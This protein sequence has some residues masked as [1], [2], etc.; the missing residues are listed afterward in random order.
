M[1]GF[2]INQLENHA[3]P[4]MPEQWYANTA[5]SQNME[6]LFDELAS[7]DGAERVKS[8]PQFMQNLGFAPD[9]R[10]ADLMVT[11]FGQLNAI[12]GYPT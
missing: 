11:D 8:Q 5:A 1:Q 2:D 6:T 4:P 9:A 10:I 3:G 7:L 12:L